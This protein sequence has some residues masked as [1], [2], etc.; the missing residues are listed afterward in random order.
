MVPRQI[1]GR[2][3]EVIGDDYQATIHLSPLN[4]RIV[5]KDYSGQN[6]EKLTSR[7]IKSAQK[8]NYTK[9]WVKAY[10]DDAEKF[11]QSGFEKEALIDSYY[12]QDDAV[13]MAY[14]L[15][16]GREEVVDFEEEE[17]IIKKLSKEERKD[18]RLT[19]TEEYKFK[20]AEE[21]DLERLAALYDEVFDSYPYPIDKVDYLR[22]ML[23]EDVIYGLIYEGDKLVAAASAETV[24]QEKNSEMT[25]FATLPEYQGQGLASYLLEQLED[26]L[27]DKDYNC[28]YT[29]ARAK[30]FGINKLFSRAGYEYKGRLIQN[31]NIGGGLEDMNLWC[32]II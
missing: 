17:K 24:P 23:T 27:K 19:L 11:S 16:S 2:K 26:I 6:I 10:R 8:N 32:K 14:Y 3:E 7:L 21:R 12:S 13:S 29:I 20:L 28:L 4:K 1:D 31:C 22:R 25:D 18:N 30:V 15:S 9:I 5:I